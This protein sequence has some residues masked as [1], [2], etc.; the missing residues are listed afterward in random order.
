M[1][2]TLLTF[3]PATVPASFASVQVWPAGCDTLSLHDA[4]PIL[5]AAAK[6][7]PPFAEIERLSPPLFCSTTLPLRPE[8]VPPTVKELKGQRIDTILTFAPYTVSAS[9]ATVQVWP[10]GCAST[11]TA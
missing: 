11:V 6:V 7:K 4:L 8:T 5:R 9:F 2:V 10:A 3:A 1:T